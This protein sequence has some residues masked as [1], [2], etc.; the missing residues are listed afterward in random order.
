MS[1]Q[2]KFTVNLLTMA[3]GWYRAYQVSKLDRKPDSTLEKT[4]AF[5]FPSWYSA[6]KISDIAPGKTPQNETW[7]T[8]GKVIFPSAYAAYQMAKIKSPNASLGEKALAVVFSPLYGAYA[9]TV[10]SERKLPVNPATQQRL[11]LAT[12]VPPTIMVRPTVVQFQPYN[13]FPNYQPLYPR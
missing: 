6:F 9:A 8:I 13:F 1:K 3:L 7:H 4:A 5:F 10:L 11:N 2:A 12:Q